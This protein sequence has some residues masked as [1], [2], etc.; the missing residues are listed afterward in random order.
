[1]TSE[2]GYIVDGNVVRKIEPSPSYEPRRE[3]ERRPRPQ[4]QP[5]PKT[6][7]LSVIVITV[8]VMVSLFIC[9]SYLQK[10]WQLKTL[11]NKVI[12]LES[13]V[14][15]TERENAQ[16]R[17]EV[18]SATDLNKIYSKATKKLG[19]VHASESQVYTYQIKK[20]NQVKQYADIPTK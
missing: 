18:A 4:R 6:D 1:M 9:F 8:A 16:A 15:S 13:E 19:M 7:V 14:V 20:D 2:R 5:K 3:V 10:Q 17:E 11:N 12:A